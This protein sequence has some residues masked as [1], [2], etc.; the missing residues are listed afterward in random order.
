MIHL[1]EMSYILMSFELQMIS[2]AYYT[3]ENYDGRDDGRNT[4]VWN[5][6]IKFEIACNQTRALSLNLPLRNIF[7]AHAFPLET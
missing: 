7:P 2:Y 6:Q 4:Q 5:L 3:S 1:N